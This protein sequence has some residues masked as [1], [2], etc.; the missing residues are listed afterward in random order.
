MPV[1]QNWYEHTERDNGLLWV[2]GSPGTGK[3]TLMKH[4]L[5]DCQTKGKYAIAAYFFNAR[6]AELEKTPLGMLRSL[7]FQLLQ[8]EPS[9]YDHFLPMFRKKQLDYDLDWD[10]C[11]PELASFFFSKLQ[12]CQSRPLLIMID[13]LDECVESDVQKVAE[14]LQRLST[15]AMDAGKTLKICLSSRHYPSIRFKEYQELVLEKEKQHDEDIFK[16]ISSNLTQKNEEIEE[17]LRKKSSGIFMW[18]V[19]VIT[20]LNRAYEDGKIEVMKQMLDKIPLKLEEVFAMLLDSDNPDN[21]DK[22]ETILILQCVLFA[23]RRLTPEE[24]YFAIITGTNRQALCRWNPLH[25]TP[26]IIRRR[27]TSSSKGLVEI[28]KSDE[29]SQVI[30][31]S[32]VQ[33]Q[34]IKLKIRDQELAETHKGEG[35]TVQF[36]HGSVNDFLLRNS[37]L[38]RLDPGLKPDPV[39]KSHDRLTGCCMAY[40]MMESLELQNI[41]RIESSFPFLGYASRYLF[42]HAEE[43]TPVGQAELLRT[44]KD[45]NVFERVER[46]HN[47]FV[48]YGQ[49][50]EPLSLL[51]VLAARGL[52]RMVVSLLDGGADIN[53]Q[54][55]PCGTALEAAIEFESEETVQTLLIKGAK[56][57]PPRRLFDHSTLYS[58]FKQRNRGI[59]AM[60]I[61]R[62][63]TFGVVD[64]IAEG[65][66]LYKAAETGDK[67]IIAMVLD[68]GAKVNARGLGGNALCAAAGLGY[69]DIVEMLLEKGANIHDRGLLGS[70]LAFAAGGGHIKVVKLLIK[71]GG[72][73][74]GRG[75][76][77]SPLTLAA[78]GGHIEVVK[79]LLEKGANINVRGL[80]GSPI[81]YAE[82]EG[83]IEVVKLLLEKGAN[84]N[85][86]GFLGSPLALAAS[87]GHIEVVKLLLELGT[88][89]HNQAFFSS[90]L[91]LAAIGG[92][93]EVVK[94][95]LKKGA[96][97]NDRGFLGS[98]L[99]YAAV[100]EH[101]EV[102]KLLLEKGANPNAWS[103]LFGNA[104]HSAVMKGNRDIAEMLLEK[105]ADINARALI[106]PAYILMHG[107]DNFDGTKI[108]EML[109]K[110]GIK[111]S[112]WGKVYGTALQGA[113]AKGREEIVQ[114]L[115][116]KGAKA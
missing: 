4:I 73:I 55:V 80:W 79:L 20:M 58:A 46:F 75:L 95:L 84:V 114:L 81:V 11:E 68:K 87:V 2:K 41:D 67:D 91:A 56:I 116:D 107:P 103:A 17:E 53:A 45:D 108:Q 44:L 51:Q 70:P 10:W 112:V 54:G 57:D 40:L 15:S 63:A 100:G 47:Y 30:P 50:G 19:L 101:M 113:A 25:I 33:S 18:V 43:A 29:M 90:P 14:F 92:H 82:L 77:G 115:L 65:T 42:D 35:E 39:A 26:D 74:S 27:I 9:L 31:G 78:G 98:P 1:F 23:K 38:Q 62:G 106:G 8:H 66:V 89:I 86:R 49:K 22:D 59:L 34:G 48:D 109:L 16:Y 28:C 13:A 93:L 36:I 105:G 7:L 60:L 96:N 6:G 111:M 99:V 102:V 94:L 85:D 3:S 37:R 64:R 83:H 104:L 52:P 32:D 24:I 69:E 71:K 5:Q 21:P 72:N 61:D 76:L 12:K 110:K 97:I 88:N